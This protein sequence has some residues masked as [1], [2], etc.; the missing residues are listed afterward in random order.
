MT[1]TTVDSISARLD[2]TFDVAERAMSWEVGFSKGE[3]FS[4]NMVM[5]RLVHIYTGD[6]VVM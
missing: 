6:L 5:Q 1:D 4:I 2:G 3:V